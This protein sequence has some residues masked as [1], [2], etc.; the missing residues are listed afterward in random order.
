MKGGAGNRAVRP[1]RRKGIWAIEIVD[2]MTAFEGQSFPAV[3]PYEFL[4]LRV[5]ARIDPDDPSNAGI[6]DCKPRKCRTDW[7]I[8]RSTP[9]SSNRLILAGQTDALSGIGRISD[10]SGLARRKFP[11]DLSA[12]HIHA[13][14]TIPA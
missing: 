4:R 3:G 2:R 11:N 10:I 9:Q 8:M 5:Q 7:S 1:S 6:S 13:G 14:R 12:H